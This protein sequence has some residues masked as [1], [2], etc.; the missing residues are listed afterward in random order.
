MCGVLETS[1]SAAPDGF[2]WAGPL[3]SGM[4]T[5]VAGQT[6]TA[7][8]TNLLTELQAGDDPR[9]R[10]SNSAPIIGGV[11]TAKE[12]ESV[13]Y[14]LTYVNTGTVTVGVLKDVLPAGVTYTPGSA[15]GSGDFTFSGYDSGEPN[16]DLGRGR[17]TT[18]DK[19]GTV[20]YAV[21]INKGAAALAQPLTNHATIDSAETEPVTVTSTVFVP[22]PPLADTAPPTDVAG[23]SGDAQSLGGQLPVHPARPDGGAHRDHP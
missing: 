19:T 22:P 17:R 4:V 16:A 2:D 12:G 6:V 15:T 21:T 23:T 1:R 7:E 10:Q 8:V 3:F 9:R 20:T 13:T 11:H 14:T 5:I 18:T